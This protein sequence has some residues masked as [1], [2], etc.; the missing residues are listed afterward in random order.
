MD[1][2]LFRRGCLRLARLE[3]QLLGD[4]GPARERY[5]GLREIFQGDGVVKRVSE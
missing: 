5:A 2:R 3:T 4:A 1:F